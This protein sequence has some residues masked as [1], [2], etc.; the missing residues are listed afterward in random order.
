MY[1]GYLSGCTVFLDQNSDGV[2]DASDPSATTTPFGRF[3]LAVMDSVDLADKSV[4]VKAGD[5]CKDASTG[6]DL[7]VEMTVKAA[8]ATEGPTTS[9]GMASLIT[10]I[11]GLFAV[12]DDAARRKEIMSVGLA[13]GE[14]FDACKY[15]PLSAAWSASAIEQTTFANF[16]QTNVELTTLV[17]TLSDVTGYADAET[18]KQAS[19]AILLGI[20]VLFETFAQDAATSETGGRRLAAA[21]GISVGSAEDI[22]ALISTASVA[23]NVPVPPELVARLAESTA[24]LMEVLAEQVSSLVEEVVASQGVGG[25]Q[26]DLASIANSMQ[27]LA[28]ASVVSQNANVETKALLQASTPEEIA[29]GNVTASVTSFSSEAFQQSMDAIV[30]PEAVQAQSPM[31]PPPPA[32]PPTPSPPPPALPPALPSPSYP[33]KK[34]LGTLYEDESEITDTE[35]NGLVGLLAL[36]VLLPP[37]L[38]VGYVLTRYSGKVPAYL[39]Y[40][41]SHTNPFIVVGY[42]P[43]ERRD[44]L[45]AEIKAPKAPKFVTSASAEA[46]VAEKDSDTKAASAVKIHRI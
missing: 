44:A 38:C 15:D 4:V 2:H 11:H 3:E 45:W 14:D 16:T 33:P 35:K 24:V 29:S 37:L 1:S 13:L 32:P 20:A 10:A 41:F 7:A 23:T 28:K 42:M 25:D 18:Y 8:C 46:V 30:V 6:L 12:A 22:A 36:L 27:D 19:E 5:G 39:S 17:K 40:R 9:G 31:P 21:G 43:K 26:A 34:G